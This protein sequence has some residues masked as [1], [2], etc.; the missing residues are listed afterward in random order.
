MAGMTAQ[1]SCRKKWLGGR[2]PKL[3][4]LD[5]QHMAVSKRPPLIGHSASDWQI[6][7]L[8]EAKR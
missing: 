2:V 7:Q 5:V 1:I 8:G 6:Q 3:H 4:S